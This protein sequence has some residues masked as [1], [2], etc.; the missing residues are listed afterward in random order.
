[1]SRLHAAMP[2]VPLLLALALA[3]AQDWPTRQPIKVIAP[4]AAASATDVADR[5]MLEQVSRQI[6]L[7]FVFENRGG[8]GATLGAGMMTQ[9]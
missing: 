8:A 7:R 6:G 5:I 9:A 2:A 1:M 4:F 3:A